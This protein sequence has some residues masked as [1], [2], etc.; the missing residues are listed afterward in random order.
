MH[1]KS[2]RSQEMLQAPCC[3]NFLKGNDQMAWDDKLW[4]TIP[5]LCLAMTL[6]SNLQHLQK[7]GHDIVIFNGNVLSHAWHTWCKTGTSEKRMS[8]SFLIYATS[9]YSNQLTLEQW[10]FENGLPFFYTH[11]RDLSSVIRK[12]VGIC[13]DKRYKKISWT[14]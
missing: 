3:S 8:C 13:W 14:V 10:A 5:L 4:A 1:D 2:S 11:C 6:L 9:K 7:V 12:M